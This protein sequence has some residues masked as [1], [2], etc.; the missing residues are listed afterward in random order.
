MRRVTIL[1][2][3]STLLALVAGSALGGRQAGRPVVPGTTSYACSG[4][5]VTLFTNAN[6]QPTRGGGTPPSF[7][8]NGKRYCLST[9]VTRHTGARAAG[10]VGLAV[11]SGVGGGGQLIGLLSAKLGAGGT[12][13]A[14][15]ATPVTI[16]GTYRCADSDPKTWSTNSGAKGLGFCTVTG[17]PA[18]ATAAVK[19]A[20]PTYSCIGSQTTLFDNSN[21]GLVSGG[22]KPPQFST[23]ATV[24]VGTY[25]LNSIRTYHWNNGA[26]KTPGTIG[27]GT[28]SFGSIV[29]PVPPRQ[30]TGS[31]GSNNAPNVNWEVDYSTSTPTIIS[32]I[33]TCKDSD[34]STWSQDTQTQ[35]KGFCVVTATPAYVNNFVLP[36][37]VHFTQP[38]PT[39]YTVV[40][41]PGSVR[42]FTGTL[43]TILLNPI[44]ASQGGTVMLLLQC[45][46]PQANGFQGRLSPASV[47]VI[48][49]GCGPFW[50]YP[51]ASGNPPPPVFLHYTGQP[52]APCSTAQQFIQFSVHGPWRLDLQATDRS[53]GAPLRTGAYGVF[54]RT[55]N[56]DVQAQNTLNIP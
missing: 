29:N 32:G 42:C 12:W 40:H 34:P 53:S 4:A 20:K 8:T 17:V 28:V 49:R 13:T 35:G 22:G 54:V 27:L 1:V 11:V 50:T 15:A 43:S 10:A 18:V 38:A 51:F 5:P 7:S 56:G 30:A 48:P 45:G 25:C 55:A 39:G 41:H 44:H 26:G 31:A 14:S 24:G 33:Y 46:I 47:F 21:G 37:G 9:L 2:I 23:Y 16:D 36:A 19:P 6:T 3:S 52:N